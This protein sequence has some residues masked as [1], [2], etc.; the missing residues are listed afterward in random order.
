MRKIVARRD[1]LLALAGGALLAAVA[2]RA[3][4]PRIAAETRGV[5]PAT[6]F[7]H[8][9]SARRIG[10]AYL[11]ERPAEADADRLRMLIAQDVPGLVHAG[12]APA[13]LRRAVA[14]RQ[15]RDFAERRTVLVRGWLLSQTEARLCALATLT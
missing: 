7:R 9:D 12:I 11:A 15:H 13:A 4:R 8:P 2:P 14:A 1:M 3:A 6:L 10:R 5:F